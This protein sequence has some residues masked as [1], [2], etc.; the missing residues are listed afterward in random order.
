MNN[1]ISE[2]VEEVL[3][4]FYGNLIVFVKECEAI[5]DKGNIDSLKQFEGNLNKAIV[6][7]VV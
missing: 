7:I 1:R 5:I 3:Q 2:Y 6:G 4:S